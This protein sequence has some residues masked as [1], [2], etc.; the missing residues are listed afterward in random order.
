MLPQ[1][2][3]PSD[4]KAHAEYEKRLAFYK[5]QD[6]GRLQTLVIDAVSTW[7]IETLRLST[8]LPP[9]LRW[10]ASSQQ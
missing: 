9:L 8:C 7:V 10:L 4:E 6:W 1:P 3:S 5:N 2:P